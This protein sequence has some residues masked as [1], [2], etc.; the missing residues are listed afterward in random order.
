MGTTIFHVLRELPKVEST[1]RYLPKP[2]VLAVLLGDLRLFGIAPVK[3]KPVAESDCFSGLD[4][5]SKANTIDRTK[6]RD[7]SAFG[8][9]NRHGQ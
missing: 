1:H 6:E 2:S 3:H 4:R 7:R 9:E 5:R 8:T